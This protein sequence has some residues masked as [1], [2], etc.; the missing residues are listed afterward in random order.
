MPHQTSN[1]ANKAY[2]IKG[3]TCAD[4]SMKIESS[5]KERYS[6]VK[7]NFPTRRLARDEDTGSSRLPRTRLH[8]PP[9]GGKQPE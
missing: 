7:L 3:L 5:L 1:T 8:L 6:N 9:G 4:C 2:I